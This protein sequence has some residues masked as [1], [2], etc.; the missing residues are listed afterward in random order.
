[1]KYLTFVKNLL[2]LNNFKMKEKIIENIA[3]CIPILEK[4]KLCI[5][6]NYLHNYKLNDEFM[7]KMVKND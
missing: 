2:I 5:Y 1:M 7:K 4:L 6:N 3:D